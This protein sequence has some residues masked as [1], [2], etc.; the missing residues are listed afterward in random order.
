M[1]SLRLLSTCRKTTILRKTDMPTYEYKCADCGSVFEVRQKF[2][3]EP[4][5]VH[6]NCGGPVHRLLSAPAFQL[7]G[8]G[9]YATDYAK[10][11]SNG[12]SPGS[13]SSSADDA[14]KETPKSD[15][16]PKSESASPATA[17]TSGKSEAGR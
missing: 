15:S 3:D 11:N 2:S 12:R 9:W 7:K 8:S 16:P 17:S 6:E 4:L 5:T 1:R 13:S 14:K 10:G